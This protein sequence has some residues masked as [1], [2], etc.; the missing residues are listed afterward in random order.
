MIHPFIIYTSPPIHYS[1]SIQY[2]SSFIIRSPSPCHLSIFLHLYIKSSIY[3]SP[4]TTY[5]PSTISP[6]SSPS[7]FT[8]PSSVFQDVAA[9]HLIIIH[10][11]PHHHL[12]IRIQPFIIY[13]P[14]TF[15]LHFHSSQ[16]VV[17]WPSTCSFI[18]CF[19][20]HAPF[21]L[22]HTS[23]D[24]SIGPTSIH[25][26]LP[27]IHPSSMDRCVKPSTHYLSA[28]HPPSIH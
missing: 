17:H 20:I 22:L 28:I 27:F 11:L 9:C 21:S 10:S 14:P 3:H 6:T 19:S 12:S 24:P 18:I 2:A 7:L 13:P 23:Q 1:L 16:T 8:F 4:L 25:I 26:Y 5:N 15:H